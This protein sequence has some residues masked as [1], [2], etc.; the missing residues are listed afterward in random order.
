[1]NRVEKSLRKTLK[2]NFADL[3]SFFKTELKNIKKRIVKQQGYQEYLK[4]IK[5]MRKIRSE[6]ISQYEDIETLKEEREALL[7]KVDN[8]STNE[9]MNFTI[10][11]DTI[12]NLEKKISLIKNKEELFNESVVGD[13]SSKVM[14]EKFKPILSVMGMSFQL[15]RKKCENR[16][17]WMKEKLEMTREIMLYEGRIDQYLGKFF[18]RMQSMPHG[19][20]CF[21]KSQLSYSFFSLIKGNMVVQ[22]KIFLKSFFMHVPYLY[23]KEFIIYNYEFFAFKP[24]INNQIMK[25]DDMMKL[26]EYRSK[27]KMQV[28]DTYVNNWCFLVNM[29]KD[30]TEFGTSEEDGEAKKVKMGTR[31]ARVLG[32][33]AEKVFNLSKDSGYGEYFGVFAGELLK[34]IPFFGNVPFLTTIVA[35]ILSYLCDF[36]IELIQR[37]FV[38]AKPVVHNFMGHMARVFGSLKQYEVVNLDYSKYI[39]TGYNIEL[40]KELNKDPEDDN[41]KLNVEVDLIEKKY[42]EAVQ[43]T[44]SQVN[45]IDALFL[46]NSQ[47]NILDLRKVAYNSVREGLERLK[48]EGNLPV[49]EFKKYEFFMSMNKS[50]LEEKELA[51]KEQME[52][53]GDVRIEGDSE[54][55][56][57][58]KI[59]ESEISI[60]DDLQ[61]LDPDDLTSEFNYEENKE[62]YGENVKIKNIASEIK[63]LRKKNKDFIVAEKRR[64]RR[65]VSV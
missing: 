31:I 60:D 2:K 23:A 32:V 25:D 7:Q 41:A 39:E 53:P 18:A 40:D 46:F 29:Y 62:I 49:S 16:L 21:T 63:D 51:K 42:L 30:H 38:K 37:F 17:V 33:T 54:T 27:M 34:M 9:D 59:D 64:P 44:E 15:L 12:E 48:N 57:D 8:L 4:R 5:Y 65:L 52:M 3:E 22:E 19:Y 58:L 35:T 36:V 50:I 43:D 61:E 56:G 1:V 6:R 14:K 26:T 20:R 45:N 24:F 11:K 13:N 55:S 10:S 28:V 47:G